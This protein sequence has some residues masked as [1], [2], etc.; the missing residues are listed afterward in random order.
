[1]KILITGVAGFVGMHLAL[2]LID[3]N[4]SVYGLDNINDYYDTDL[5]YAR[6]AN[7][8]IIKDRIAYDTELSGKSNF[9]FVKLDL[10]D[11]TN[12]L[13]LF[14]RSHFD[15]VI[16]LAAQAGVRYSI[17]NPNVYMEY[18]VMGFF[19]ILEACKR[20]PVKHLLFASSSSV[21]GNNPEIPFRENQRTDEPISLYASTKKCNE[22]IAYTYAHLYHFPITGLRFF[23]VYGP[24]G[25]PDMAY[26]IFTKN[27]LEGRK[28]NLFNGGE[29]YRDFTYIDDVVES[30]TR[31]I[32]NPSIDKPAYRI[33][34][35]GK[36]KAERIADFVSIIEKLVGKK[37]NISIS[38][39]QDGDVDITFS[40]SSYL[41]D[42]IEFEPKIDLQNG[43]KYFIDWYKKFFNVVL[44]DK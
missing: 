25:R 38:G 24:W 22:V 20:Y 28:V 3:M 7:L 33:L 31:L 15:V 32:H 4:Y 21:Y 26:F 10:V 18:N 11:A 34:N 43:L 8:G 27:I 39:K 13:K 37:A 40:D 30:I 41:I 12:L 14:Q 29:L 9:T 1:M 44:S 23:T 35:I 5:K 16:N 2:K 19:N 6:L 36:Q 42:L 17:E